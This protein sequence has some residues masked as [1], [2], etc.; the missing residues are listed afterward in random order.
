[1]TAALLTM[2]DAELPEAGDRF[3]SQW[4]MRRSGIEKISRG[5]TSHR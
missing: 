1:M 3:S 4:L 2:P 5:S